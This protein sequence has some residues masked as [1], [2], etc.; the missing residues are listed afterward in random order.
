M[1][2]TKEYLMGQLEALKVVWANEFN[3][4]IEFSKDEIERWLVRINKNDEVDN[5]LHQSELDLREFKRQFF[6]NKNK[7]KIIVSPLREYIEEW[8]KKALIE[9]TEPKNQEIVRSVMPLQPQQM[10]IMEQA[11]SK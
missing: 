4:T 9:I 5:T 11:S 10:S 8:L 6:N 2:L 3:E 7:H 1:I